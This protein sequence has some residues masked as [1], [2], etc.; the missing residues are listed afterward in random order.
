[1]A[2]YRH[3]RKGRQDRGTTMNTVFADRTARKGDRISGMTVTF[4]DGFTWAGE[5]SATYGD[6]KLTQ[7]VAACDQDKIGAIFLQVTSDATPTTALT[8]AHKV[9]Q[10]DRR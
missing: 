10:D 4:T 3:S 6:G 9:Y 1:M 7:F 5:F 8:Y 2:N